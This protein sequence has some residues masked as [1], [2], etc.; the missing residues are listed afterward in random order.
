MQ[1][2][3]LFVIET[4]PNF[5][6]LVRQPTLFLDLI[7]A[8]EPVETPQ[9]GD[10]PGRESL[11]QH[12]VVEALQPLLEEVRLQREKET[13]TIT[14]H[15]KISLGA[16][17]N[18]QNLR[19]GELYQ[20]QDD[21]ESIPFLDAN[22]KTTEDRIDELNERL[23]RRLKELDREKSCTI[24]DITHL[25]RAWILPHPERKNPGV[26]PMVRDDDI[27]VIAVNK[28]MEYEQ[29]RGWNPVS[30][31][32]ENR[33]FD[34]ISRKPHAEDPETAV[35]VRFIEVK[36]RAGIG[37][38]AVSL[39]EH[40]TA[41]RLKDDYWLYVV[42]NCASDPQVYPI[43]NPARLGWQ[44]IVQIEHYHLNPKEILGAIK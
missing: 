7:P 43:R 36:G 16:L 4:L 1:H 35:D 6:M 14:D 28:A 21:D 5:T 42:F 10:W 41:E 24:G 13:S 9:D 39:N 34:L 23:E 26:A 33:G 2:R 44:P 11:E 27:E 19:I 15:L 30:V 25:G 12:L 37:E 32:S 40:K 22:I 29:A 18:R 38:I 8:G 17:I 3:R 20:A 31:E